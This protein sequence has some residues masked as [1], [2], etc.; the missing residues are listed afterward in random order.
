[1]RF[2]SMWCSHARIFS[3][4]APP[5]HLKDRD[6]IDSILARWKRSRAPRRASPGPL[7][8]VERYWRDIASQNF[9]A[10]YRELAAGSSSQSETS[11][12][13]AEQHSQIQS[14]TFSGS[15]S[16]ASVGAG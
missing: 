13:S 15:L 9:D 16:S 12:V 3:R 8:V 11:F 10:A 2:R 4:S 6:H 7:Q 14:A 5:T 1:M